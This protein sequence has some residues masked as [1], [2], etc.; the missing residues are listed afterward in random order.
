MQRSR[1]MALIA[2]SVLVLALV[3]LYAAA[4]ETAPTPAGEEAAWHDIEARYQSAIREPDEYARRE[5]QTIDDR[6]AALQET[7]AAHERELAALREKIEERGHLLARL[8]MRKSLGISGAVAFGILLVHLLIYLYRAKEP[9]FPFRPALLAALVIVVLFALPAFAAP[10]APDFGEASAL[11]A[12]VQD[13][14]ADSDVLTLVKRALQRSDFPGAINVLE[15]ASTGSL[16]MFGME[17]P[18]LLDPHEEL[19]GN[20][21]VTLVALLGELYEKQG[22][23]DSAEGAYNDVARSAAE[24]V[25]FDTKSVR[26]AELRVLFY[27]EQFWRKQKQEQRLRALRPIYEQVQAA[28]LAELVPKLHQGDTEQL[29]KQRRELASREDQNAAVARELTARG[30]DLRELNRKLLLEGGQVVALAFALVLIL[31]GCAR[32]ARERMRA[33]P[34]P[35]A[36]VVFWSFTEALGWVL[37]FSVVGAWLGLV[38]VMG[39]R[40]R[41]GQSAVRSRATVST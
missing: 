2:A 22:R 23:L 34:S 39:A 27:V 4:E 33:V 25:R 15:H 24:W 29:E 32:Y 11:R 28:T 3:P 41:L 7:L 18:E 30:T 17:D 13:S 1:G 12:A 40:F 8:D 38:A 26:P 5:R 16:T 10:A 19:P 35:G 37:V 36:S 6:E 14:Q 21:V 9:P 20:R 31:V